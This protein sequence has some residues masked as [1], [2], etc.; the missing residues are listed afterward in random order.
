MKTKIADSI[1]TD[2]LA[3]ALP[4]RRRRRRRWPYMLGAFIAVLAGLG[5]YMAPRIRR[6]Y[7]SY[8]RHDQPGGATRVEASL[9]AGGEVRTPS[10]TTGEP[11]Q[12]APTPSPGRAGYPEE[13][14]ENPVPGPVQERFAGR[15]SELIDRALLDVDGSPMGSVEAVYYRRMRP[16]PEWA[17]TTVSAG[18][19]DRR[20]LVPLMD[21]TLTEDESI[22]LA[23]QKEQ[24]QESPALAAV[25]LDEP[26]EIDLYDHYHVRR[27]VSGLASQPGAEER[28]LRMWTPTQGEAKRQA[29]PSRR[30]V[31]EEGV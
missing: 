9:A 1:N 4:L 3:A 15:F 28:P 12:P 14:L 17:A 20:V 8:R 21:A 31:P 19:T 7:M 2:K 18:L 6:T 30:R 24:V 16:E 22:M 29:A 23:Y 26:T 5:A 13:N 25:V 11:A 27:M 10:G